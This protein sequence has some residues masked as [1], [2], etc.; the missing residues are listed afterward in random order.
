MN[1]PITTLHLKPCSQCGKEYSG[2]EEWLRL[3]SIPGELQFCTLA[4]AR[5]YMRERRL[6]SRL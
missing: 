6:E 4:Y 5:D 1:E 3:D 2:I